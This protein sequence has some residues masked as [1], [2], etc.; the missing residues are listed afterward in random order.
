M[1]PSAG[2]DHAMVETPDGHGRLELVKFHSPSVRGGDGHAPAN[3]LQEST[4]IRRSRRGMTSHLVFY[5][6]APTVLTP[7]VVLNLTSA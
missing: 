2:R 3:I 4:H 6:V 5:R 7:S 1:T